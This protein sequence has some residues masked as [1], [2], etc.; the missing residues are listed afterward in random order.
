MRAS[1]AQRRGGLKLCPY[2]STHTERA[3]RRKDTT[4]FVNTPSGPGLVRR[5]CYLGQYVT[6]RKED[7]LFFQKAS[8]SRP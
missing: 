5:V 1:H 7:L 2:P 8:K 6:Q 3:R 4:G